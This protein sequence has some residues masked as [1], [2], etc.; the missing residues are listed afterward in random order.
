MAR[1]CAEAGLVEK[2]V[3][4]CFKAGRRAIA[5]GAMTEAVAQLRKGLDLLSRVDQDTAHYERELDLQMALGQALL[6]TNGYSAPEP[7]EAYARARHLCEQ[8]DRWA[9]LGPIFMVSL[10]FSS[11]GENWGRRSVT[12]RR[13][14]I[15]AR[16]GTKLSGGVLVQELVASSAACLAS[17]PMPACTPRMLSPY[18]TRVIAPRPRPRRI[19]TCRPCCI[20][21]GV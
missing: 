16:P 15:W 1:H 18:G 3:D 8:L 17:S 12:L 9:Q 11:S 5:K 7:G 14:A 4:Y 21:R 6:A 2:A 13:C 19:R 10:C 20:C